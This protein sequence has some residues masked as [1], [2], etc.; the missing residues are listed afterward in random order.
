MAHTFSIWAMPSGK[1]KTQLQQQ[2]DKFVDKYQGVKFEP[3]VTVLGAFQTSKEDA[4]K[5]TQNLASKLKK[6]FLKF[7]DVSFGSQFF[8]CVYL[9]INEDEEVMNAAK[10][11]REEIVGEVDKPYMPHL[12]LLYSDIDEEQRKIVVKEA[13]DD[14]YGPQAQNLLI[15]TGFWAEELMLWETDT[16]NPSSWKLVDKFQLQ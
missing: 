9:L 3:H 12:S 14:L 8:Q 1:L 7:K 16:G 15:D 13:I 5:K 4:I 2:I 11:A 6:Y 10:V